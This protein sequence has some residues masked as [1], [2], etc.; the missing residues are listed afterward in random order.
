MNLL[1]DTQALI[2][3]VENDQRLS[4]SVKA[5]MED[6]ESLIISIASLWEITIKVSLGKL[7]FSKELSSF[8]NKLVY[9]GFDI[10]P[11][12]IAH[13]ITLQSLQNVHKDPFDRLIIAQAI[14]EQIS[15]VSSDSI[16][17]E[18]PVNIIW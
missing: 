1:I 3:F 2:W 16:F 14:K 11:I 5:I 7:S 18:Y 15:I 6:S 8:F 9:N 17:K 4:P 13:L 10:M 12:K